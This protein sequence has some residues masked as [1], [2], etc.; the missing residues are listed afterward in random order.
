MRAPHCPALEHVSNAL[1]IKQL[2]EFLMI[3]CV[4]EGDQMTNSVSAPLKMQISNTRNACDPSFLNGGSSWVT[5]SRPA[6]VT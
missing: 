4:L 6:Q 3:L 5:S 2:A 1:F